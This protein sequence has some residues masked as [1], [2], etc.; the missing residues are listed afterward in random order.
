[1][2]GRSDDEIRCS[3]CGKSQGQVRKLIAGP[4]GAYI[5]DECVDVCAE[6]IEEEFEYENGREW[7]P[8]SDINLL[9]P[10]EI[11]AF[12]DEYVFQKGIEFWGEGINYFD[13]KRLEVGIHRAYKGSNCERYQ[14][15]IDM[16]GA[17]VG[18]TP[19]WNQAEL[20]AN[21]AIFHYN[22]PYTNPTTY[23]V[24]KSNDELRPYYGTEITE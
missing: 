12:L 23:Y 7:N 19:G 20:N 15:C 24:F 14:H 8:F 6:I 22:N 17:Y 9:K 5:C 4:K 1:M 3:F 18:W 2:A 21:P 16:D 13:A 10:E 11:K